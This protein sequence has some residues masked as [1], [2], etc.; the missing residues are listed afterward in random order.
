MDTFAELG[1]PP[2]LVDA[3]AAEGIESP[4]PLQRDAI[5]LL[6]RGNN[7]LVRAGPG[8]GTLVA[9]GAPLLERIQAEATVPRALVL[10]ASAAAAGAL[11]TSLAR[12][13]TAT[14]HAVAAL[15]SPWA[16]PEHSDIL[17]ATA[18]DLLAAVRNSRLRLEDFR[19]LVV[20]G[21]ATIQ[22]SDGL[23]DLETLIGFVPATAQRVVVSLPVTP[24]VAAFARAHA[25]K[26]GYVAG[27]GLPPG[28]KAGPVRG[29]LHYRICR[30]SDADLVRAVS[31]VLE[32]GA[33]HVLVFCASDDHAA[34]VGD[35]A[36]LHGFGAGA[37]GD[38]SAPVWL[39]GRVDDTEPPALKGIADAT[40][41]ATL[42]V[43]VP[44][45][46]GELL[47]R[48]GLGAAAT[49][50]V[51]H[52]EVAHLKAIA[53]EAGHRL[54]PLPTPPR[55]DPHSELERRRSELLRVLEEEDLA[56]EM[57]LLDPLFERHHPVEV[58]AAA[59]RLAGRAA[60]NPSAYRRRADGEARRGAT[61]SA[62]SPA[63]VQLPVRAQAWVRLFVSV[64]SRDGIGPGDL[65][66]AAVDQAGIERAQVGR[67]EIQETFTRV[68]IRQQ[69]AEKVV[70]ALNGITLGGRAVR[71]D[72]HREPARGPSRS[73]GGSGRR[74]VKPT[75]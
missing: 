61:H 27:S 11:A 32:Q 3:L 47:H 31:E 12:L 69:V 29:V 65:L 52:R 72:Y 75:S 24:E 53:A 42:S 73:R 26:A 45:G 16:A 8:S 30:R 71:V 51:L 25:K 10:T 43:D 56:S 64:G 55:A 46:A 60:K 40:S 38:A 33:R 39:S 4:T 63:A 18:P 70:R 58:A 37:P 36:S 67:I 57:L 21:A 41:V 15:G 23:E 9:Y 62:D 14:G 7:A 35:L 66:G 2:E 34:D 22:R 68:E 20:D 44:A 50:L 28:A 6:R 74:R 5:P 13:A 19:A 48:H 54:R 17:F 59:S 49:V 1:L